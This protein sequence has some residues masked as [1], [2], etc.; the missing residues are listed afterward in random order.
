MKIKRFNELL[1]EN[2]NFTCDGC[3][4]FDFDTLNRY[5]GGYEHPIYFLVRKNLIQKLEFINPKEYLEIVCKNMDITYDYMINNI[6]YH[7][8][9]DKY[10]DDMKKGDKFPIITYTVNSTSQEGRHRALAAM[11][12]GCKEIPVIKEIIVSRD[13]I[14]NQINFLKD[15][16]HK[17]NGR[18]IIDEYYKTLNYKGITDLDWRTLEERIIYGF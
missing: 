4:Y 13:E 7:K 6:I 5:Y 16:F 2:H 1:L 10:A 18:K 11:K 3:K 17:E 9:V 12:L 14:D 15:S 8:N